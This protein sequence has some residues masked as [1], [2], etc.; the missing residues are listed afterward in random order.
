MGAT[1]RARAAAVTTWVYAAGFGLPTVPVAVLPH[2]P[3]SA[4]DFLGLF[5]MYGGPWSSRL[6][7]EQFVA[8]LTAFLVLTGAAAWSARGVWRGRRAGAVANLA[9]L[10]RRGDLLGRF[11]PADP[12][13]GR[14]SSSRVARHRVE[15]T[16]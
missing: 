12:V 6:K 3:G 10:P 7:P 5:D 4:A 8:L 11:R 9:L 16:H 1:G 15:V 13:A 14:R 2:D